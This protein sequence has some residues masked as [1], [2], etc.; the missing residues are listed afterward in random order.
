M[1][2]KIKKYFKKF[3]WVFFVFLI[4]YF[5]LNFFNYF[6]PL[7]FCYIKIDS[8]FLRGNEKTI[9]KAIKL[10]KKENKIA[11]KTLCGYINTIS[12]KN[13][14]TSSQ[15]ISLEDWDKDGCYIKGSKI[16]YIK[17]E[18]DKGDTIINERKI[19]IKKYSEYSR[20]FWTNTK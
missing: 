4:F 12:E 9:K 17:P 20:D 18:K 10:L 2:E 1:Q 11:Y 3:A 16:I 5:F 8:D 13:C 15:N 14:F 6:D 19:I 7:N